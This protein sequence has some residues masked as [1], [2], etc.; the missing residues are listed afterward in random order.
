MLTFHPNSVVDF[1]AGAVV[2]MAYRMEGGEMIFPPTST[3]AVSRELRDGLV[4]RIGDTVYEKRGNKLPERIDPPGSAGPRDLKDADRQR[5]GQR[6]GRS[7]TCPPSLLGNCSNLSMVDDH[8]P[9]VTAILLA[10]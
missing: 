9:I 2:E 6:E 8:M 3:N 10:P 1:S 4:S 5:F 7:K